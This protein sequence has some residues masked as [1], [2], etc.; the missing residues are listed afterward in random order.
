MP[1]YTILTFNFNGY[2]MI[3][4]PLIIDQNAEYIC[5]SD[6][7]QESKNWK[8]IVDEKLTNKNPIYSSYYVRYH[9]FEYVNTD[10]VIVV[11]SSIQIKDQLNSFIDNFDSDLSVMCTNYRTD[12]Q[13][14][15]FWIKNRKIKESDLKSIKKFINVIKQSNEKGSIGTAFN[16]LRKTD[17]TIK[18]LNDVWNTLIEYGEYG[19]PNRLDEIVFHKLLKIHDLKKTIYS[20]QQIQS[21]YMSYMAHNQLVPIPQYQNYDQMYYLNNIPVNP[22]RLDKNINF[23]K[24]YKY[25]TEAILLTKYLNENDLKE[26]LEHHLYK[27]KFEHIVV[28]DNESDYDV[29]SICKKYKNVDYELIKGL[30]RQYKIYDEHFK[31]SKAKWIM[32]IDDDEYLDFSSEFNTVYEA[33][34]YYENKFPHMNMLAVRWKH[35]FPNKFHTERTGK[36]LDYCIEENQKLAESF[37]HLGDR[38]V[39]TI[40][41]NYGLIHYEETKENPAGGHVPKNSTFLG[42]LLFNGENVQ[43]CG[44]NKIPTDTKDEKIRLIHCR[45]KGYSE[46]LNKMKVCKTIS[47]EKHKEKHWN[48]DYILDYLP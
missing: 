36:V 20:I 41:K 5:I 4:E 40:V 9:P 46:Y 16:I 8:V 23:P 30:P 42:A 33:I 11:D 18:F 26:W 12:E 13:K 45:Y 32:P 37:M 3:R 24:E 15:D 31:K 39:K 44:T 25:N 17:N 7:H 35:L 43:G 21:T 19:V 29:K 22:E 10:T 2:D 6:T 48:F 28:Y 27:C 1:K 34:I 14:I 38:T 47:D